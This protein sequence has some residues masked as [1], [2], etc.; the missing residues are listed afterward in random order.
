M[1]VGEQVGEEVEGVV[2]LLVGKSL[3]VLFLHA[4]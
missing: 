2:L 3:F 1:W 4:E